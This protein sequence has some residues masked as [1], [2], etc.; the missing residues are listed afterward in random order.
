ML[1]FFKQLCLYKL[2]R[3]HC[4]IL[5]TVLITGLLLHS[6]ASAQDLIWENQGLVDEAA[7]ASGSTFTYN[8]AT[9]TVTWST[10]T[11]G[12]SFTNYA[13]GGGTNNSV[14]GGSDFLSYESSA[15]GNH[16]GLLLLGI[17]NS[18]FDPDDF[19]SVTLSFSTA[20]TGLAFSI[21]DVD[22]GSWD[23][24]LE[25]LYNGTNNVRA[26]TSLWEFA[27]TNTGLS[28]V[29][30][31]GEPGYTG[32]EAVNGRTTASNSINGN[33][34]LNF[35]GVSV[36][37]ISLRFFSTDDQQGGTTNPGGQKIGFSDLTV[38]PEASTVTAAI[39]LLFIGFL[40]HFGRSRIRARRRSG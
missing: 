19:L 39:C 15:E 6:S 40:S 4:R 36:N 30:V 35:D 7:V 14:G 9:L 12:G 17:D 24:G 5:F 21:L 23:D 25:I 1:F 2:L 22:A 28:S 18:A 38:V 3:S 33:I 16:T 10:T 32:W 13:S 8:G 34:D 37:S 27:Q 20:Q 11:D 29:I 26:D 31:D